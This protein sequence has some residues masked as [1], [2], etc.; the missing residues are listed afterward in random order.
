MRASPLALA[1][2]LTVGGVKA[3]LSVVPG[4]TWTATNTG[5]HVQA[6]GA[7]IIEE[8]GVYYM[9]GEEKTDGASFQAVNC[10][11]STNLVEWSFQGRLLTRTEEA[12]DLGPNRIIERPKVTKND[13]TGKY[14]LHL[15]I[16]SSDYKDAKVGVA[17]GDS[18]CGQYEYIRSFRP[19]DFQS[20]DI[21]IFKDDDGSAYLL[22]EDREYGT[23]I[24]KLTDD[25]LDVAEVTFGWEYFAESPALVKRDGTY[26]IFGSH[27]TGWNPNDN[28]YSYATSLSGP[29]SNWTEFAPVG[30]K[31]YNSQVSFVLPLGTDK[32]IYMG[33]RWHSTNLAASTYIWLPLQFDG[34]T[35]TLNWHDS[36]NLD[37][38]AGTW[39]ESTITNEIEGE[40]GALSNGARVVECSE[41]SGSAAAGYLG[42]DE[43]GTATFNFTV[44]EA[45]RVTLIVNHKNGDT[46]SRH[47]AVSVNDEDQSA[48][49]LATS[50]LSTTGSSAIHVN[51]QQGENLI[52]FSKSEGWGPDIDQLVVP[53]V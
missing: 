5:E 32:A 26:F 22:S 43:D 3:A 8:D 4:A 13:A 6:H 10:Y 14:V 24:I 50:H 37:T 40:T 2:A 49:F 31:T 27:L 1:A 18:V 52:T 42:G 12:G 34:T 53:S 30:S 48:A 16:D 29:W 38:A 15:H 21:G 39:S 41:C 51:L 36:W 46:A 28:V 33:D 45:E 7:G 11:S 23:R 17:T 44:A 25:Y 9:I 19:F 35:V 47:A 20:R